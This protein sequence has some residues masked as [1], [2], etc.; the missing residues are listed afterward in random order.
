MA[1]ALG[2]LYLINQSETGFNKKEKNI[3]TVKG[4]NTCW[5]IMTIV[6][7]A[8]IKNIFMAR[9]NSHL[10]EEIFMTMSLFYGKDAKKSI[11]HNRAASGIPKV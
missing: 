11:T 3:A 4:I 10:F 9:S 7:K 1:K 5:P 6:K 8:D 2:T